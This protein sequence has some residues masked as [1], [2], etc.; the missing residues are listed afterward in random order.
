LAVFFNFPYFMGQDGCVAAR[1]RKGAGRAHPPLRS[2]SRN[3]HHTY[4][5]R[6]GFRRVTNVTARE[7]GKTKEAKF[8][9]AMD[10]AED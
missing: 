2:L 10:P 3:A 7:A 6:S 4:N 5:T 8:Q 1:R 9:V